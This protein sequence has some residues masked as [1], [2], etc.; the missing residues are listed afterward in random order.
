MVISNND[1]TVKFFDV[2]IRS[3]KYAGEGG[4][5]RLSPAGQLVLDVPVNHCERISGLT[6]YYSIYRIFHSLN[7]SRWPNTTLRR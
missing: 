3:A 7:I 1:K 5:K 6:E 2:A 4:A